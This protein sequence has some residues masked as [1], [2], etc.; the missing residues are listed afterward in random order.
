MDFRIV[1][2]Q[3]INYGDGVPPIDSTHICVCVAE[4]KGID[5]LPSLSDHGR[6]QAERS[7]VF[8]HTFVFETVGRWKCCER[9]LVSS[10]E[11]N[12]IQ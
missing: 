10:E 8:R 4:L 1:H 2:M 7:V 9:I 11:L 5:L 12:I 3:A 6:E